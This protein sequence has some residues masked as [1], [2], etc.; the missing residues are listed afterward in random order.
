M[1]KYPPKT[2]TLVV[3]GP[4]KEELVRAKL[5]M[6]IKEKYNAAPSNIHNYEPRHTATA[7]NKTH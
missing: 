5:N 1:N 6:Y 7:A 2:F 3:E 4:S